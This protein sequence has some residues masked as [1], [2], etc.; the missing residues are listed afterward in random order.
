[1]AARAVL[2]VLTLAAGALSVGA[3]STTATADATGPVAVT[4]QIDGRP[5]A[6]STETRPIRLD[7]KRESVLSVEVVNRGGRAVSVRT[8][9][10][11]GRVIGL[12]FFA[13]DTAVGL[14]VPAGGRGSRRFTLDLGGL[15][16]QATGLIPGAV[17]LLDNDRRELASESGVV[18]VRGSLRSVYGLFGLGVATLT[19]LSFAACLI[20]LARHRLHP[21]RWRRALRF[22]TAGVG[23]GLLVNF[24]LSATRVFVPAVGRSLTIVVICSA[25]LFGLGYLTPAPDLRTAEDL[26]EE[27]EE[28]AALRSGVP[29]MALGGAPVVAAIGGIPTP[30]ELDGP[31]EAVALERGPA[32]LGPAP[33][34]E[35]V[36]EADVAPD[37]AVTVRRPAAPP[38]DDTAGDPVEPPGDERA[39]PTVIVDPDPD[40]GERAQPTVIVDPDPDAGPRHV[41][42]GAPPTLRPP[43]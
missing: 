25:V 31:A 3:G 40:A 36:D 28:R 12:A 42:D 32:G 39:H 14:T 10:L 21:N 15:D 33:G 26:E 30:G 23:L 17:K 20:G 24:T 5:L 34:A 4:A 37:P 9:R 19:V 1:M 29:A 38:D 13:Y 8:V 16:G 7:P 22:L 6:A 2:S 35:G 11:E 18:D 43:P 41:D 27:E